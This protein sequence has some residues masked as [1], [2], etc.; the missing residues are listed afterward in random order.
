MSS[1]IT[2]VFKL[3]VGLLVN[4][5]RDKAAEKLKDGDVADQKFRGLIVREIDD[6]RSKLDGLS[7]KDLLAS[8][9]FFKEGIGLLYT[10][11]MLDKASSRS[12]HGASPTHAGEEACSVAERMRK[13]EIADLDE[14]ALEALS[15]AK[16]R[17]E[18]SRR[19]A[20]EAFANEA[21]EAA[22]RILAMQYRVMATVLETIDNPEHA[23]EPCRVCLEELNSLSAVQKSFNVQLK[24][25]IQALRG[26]VGKDERR[27]IISSVCHVN[28]VIY[29]VT[30]TVGKGVHLWV[31]PAID[32]GEDKVDPLRDGRLAN[33]L[34]EQGMEHCY[35][36]PWSFGHEG[37]EEHRLNKP[38]GIATN[39]SGQ[40]IVGDINEVKMFD[41][42]GQFI[43][44]FSLPNDDAETE[45]YIWDVAT[46]NKD[47]IYV[48]VVNCKCKKET[49]SPEFVVY[50][51]SNVADLHH[52]FPV[53]GEYYWAKR[54]TVHNSKVLV[55]R[56]SS[57]DVYDTDGLYVRSFGE[58]TLKD[59]CDITAANDGRVMV[60]DWDWD[61]FCVHIFSE[62]GDYL[63]KFKLEERFYDC[64]SSRLRIAFHQ[65]TE[66]VVI[67]VMKEELV[68]G[69][70]I[71]TKDGEFVRSTQIHEEGNHYILGMTVTRDGRIAVLLRDFDHKFK[72]L[73][74]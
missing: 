52:K 20:T 40:F 68:V 16:K 46:D 59:A 55:L 73:V 63:D 44:H 13:L 19:K 64:Y 26:L 17:F 23:I 8:I 28:R 31:W 69:V 72:V 45:L 41:T 71:F 57:V 22:D 5:G 21:L 10:C 27:K 18:D 25:G 50:A 11:N 39:S 49:G 43:Q 4:K 70:K 66:S 7:K 14:S 34:R 51:F 38:R 15:K 32:I 42:T 48:L 67:A 37:E 54:L 61:D 35:V 58:G 47:N 1:I 56:S 12:E 2:A 9:S 65:L 74:I 62:D 60:L 36:T 53:R 6:I 29:D 24:K 30:H 3:T 33:V